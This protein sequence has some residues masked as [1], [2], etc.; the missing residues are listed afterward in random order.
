MATPI[1]WLAGPS[2]IIAALATSCE[3]V[4]ARSVNP[5]FRRDRLRAGLSLVGRLAER[6]FDNRQPSLPRMK[7]RVGKRDVIVVLA[8]PVRVFATS[9]PYLSATLNVDRHVWVA[10]I[11][12]SDER[13]ESPM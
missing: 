12:V 5:L 8:L 4:L 9:L 10:P 2:F 1:W 13:H 3:P 11:L 7:L 6:A